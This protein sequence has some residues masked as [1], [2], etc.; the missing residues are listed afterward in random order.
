LLFLISSFHC[1]SFPPYTQ[2]LIAPVR[3][4]FLYIS[5]NVVYTNRMANRNSDEEK[6]VPLSVV[7]MTLGLIIVGTA[8]AVWL[9]VPKA[10]QLPALMQIATLPTPEPTTD[11]EIFLLPESSET[12]ELPAHFVSAEDYVGT[13]NV[14]QPRRLVI[15][16]IGLDA[17]VSSIGL[18]PVEI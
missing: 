4:S 7:F 13:G 14:G 9:L 3:S 2:L 17:P 8:V 18:S 10:R 16:S 6:T 11:P 15:P 1:F 5:V 12:E